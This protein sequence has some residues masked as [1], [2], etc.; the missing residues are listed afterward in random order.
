MTSRFA[1]GFLRSRLTRYGFM[2]SRHAAMGR[3]G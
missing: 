3:E 1:F 2:A